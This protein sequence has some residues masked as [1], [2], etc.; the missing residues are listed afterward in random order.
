MLKYALPLTL[1]LGV[2]SPV[3]AED[4]SRSAFDPSPIEHS[5]DAR[6]SYFHQGRMNATGRSQ[7]TMGAALLF[8]VTQSIGLQLSG[9][10]ILPSQSQRT[11]GEFGLLNTGKQVYLAQDGAITAS[12][13]WT[14]IGGNSGSSPSQAP[15]I[16]AHFIIG[17]SVVG[18]HTWTQTADDPVN[19]GTRWRPALTT[20][21]GLDVQLTSRCSLVGNLLWTGFVLGDPNHTKPTPT[22]Q[23]VYTPVNIELGISWRF[24]PQAQP[25]VSTADAIEESSPQDADTPLTPVHSQPNRMTH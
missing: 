23:N 10:W 12:V 8:H 21:L 9:H 18:I 24:G 4:N 3:Q 20:G 25:V 19:N 6:L 11:H 14:L 7:H 15:P 5:L 1:A 22:P 17:P 13:H 16:Q 2:S